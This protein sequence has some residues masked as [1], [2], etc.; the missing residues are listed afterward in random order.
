MDLLKRLGMCLLLL[1][2]VAKG[3]AQDAKQVFIYCPGER[4]GLHIAQL[5]GDSWQD[6][7]QLCSSDYGS[8]GPE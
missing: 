3:Y 4:A 8:W 6:I 7:G 5:S 1:M 2:A